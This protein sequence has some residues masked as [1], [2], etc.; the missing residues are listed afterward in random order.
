[1]RAVGRA[2]G[3][4]MPFARLPLRAAV[5]CAAGV[6][7]VGGVGVLAGCES[8]ATPPASSSPSAT[9]S[10]PTGSATPSM[11]PSPSASPTVEIP[12]AA[13]QKTDKGAEAFV[14]YFFDQVNVAWMGP[15]PGLLAR[16]S[17][18]RCEFC[19]EVGKTSSELAKKG[20]RYKET[21]VSVDRFTRQGGAPA[22]QVIFEATITQH[23][24]R[25]VDAGGSVMK[26]EKA[27]EGKSRIGVIWSPDGWRLLGV[28]VA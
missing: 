4:G 17:D 15:E 7:A 20:Q 13:R 8:E 16:L 22:N 2:H 3:T 10:T 12:A 23:P 19:A 27:G 9:R 21:P 6:V 26:T 18:A 5:V 24:S 1:M 11:S 28:E 14:R 25:I